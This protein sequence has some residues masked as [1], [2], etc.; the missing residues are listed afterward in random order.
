VRQ[1]LYMTCVGTVANGKVV[2]PPGVALPDGMQVE[3]TPVITAQ[4]RADFTEGLLRI[5]GKV[6]NLPADLAANHDHYLHCLPSK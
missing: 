1:V 5:A 6:N 2:L 3:V 4:E